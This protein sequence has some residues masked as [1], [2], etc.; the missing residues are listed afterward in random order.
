MNA[1]DARRVLYL[2]V[3][4]A[5][6]CRRVTEL[7]DLLQDDRWDVHAIATPTAATWLPVAE[8]EQRTG[9]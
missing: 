8:L 3:C 1:R 5:P 2:V 6:P 7:V 4:A 9:H